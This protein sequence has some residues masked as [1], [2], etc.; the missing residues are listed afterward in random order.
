MSKIVDLSD[1]SDFEKHEC[2]SRKEG[3]L[4]IF[5]CPKCDY[6]RTYD[7]ESDEWSASGGNMYILHKGSNAPTG[8]NPAML[9]P[10]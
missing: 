4:I 10:N 6:V 2:Q 1:T 8:I 9:H 3:P 5:E 7:Q